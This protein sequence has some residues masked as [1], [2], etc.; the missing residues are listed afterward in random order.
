MYYINKDRLAS[1]R[2]RREL[3]KKKKKSVS[4]MFLGIGE[5]MK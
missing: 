4:A 1:S 3:K 5:A 2:G